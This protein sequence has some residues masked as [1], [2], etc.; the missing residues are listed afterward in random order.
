MVSVFPLGISE[1][2]I[3]LPKEHLGRAT[4][5]SHSAAPGA[6]PNRVESYI[7]VMSI[8]VVGRS[9]EEYHTTVRAKQGNG[10]RPLQFGK[11]MTASHIR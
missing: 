3:Q 2:V 8:V 4:G 11:W 7:V 10:R 9:T 5:H 1:E 6:V